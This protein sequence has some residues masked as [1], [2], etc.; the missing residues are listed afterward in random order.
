MRA[1]EPHLTHK[2]SELIREHFAFTTQPM[3]ETEEPEYLPQL[4]E[5]LG[6]DDRIMFSSDYPH[7]DFD[8]P[9]RVFPAS[10][11]GNDT[12]RQVLYDNAERYFPFS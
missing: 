4:L 1:E 3:D 7:W 2:P 10:L 12:R 11:V 5:H 8:D 6:M 9:N